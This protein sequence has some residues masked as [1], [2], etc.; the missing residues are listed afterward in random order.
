MKRK[1][2]LTESEFHSLVR[3][4]VKETQEEMNTEMSE[5]DSFDDGENEENDKMSKEDTVHAVA[6]FFKRKLRRLDSDEIENLEDMVINRKTEGLTEMFLREDI[7]DRMKSFK[8]KSMIRGGFGMMGAGMLGMVSQAM[9]YT[10]A[11]ELMTQVHDY[12]D[13]MGGGPVSTAVLIAGLVMALKGAA[14]RSERL[15]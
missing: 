6:N 12:V 3:R 13:K 8:E 15:G 2:R 14:D 4:L 7:S 11:G 9:G 1:I 10:D 5:M